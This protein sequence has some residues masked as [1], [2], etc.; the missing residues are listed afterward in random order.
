M[1]KSVISGVLLVESEELH[2]LPAMQ[3]A[4][5]PAIRGSDLV[6]PKP[7]SQ[8]PRTLSSPLG[9]VQALHLPSLRLHGL[10]EVTF[11]DLLVTLL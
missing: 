9:S 1:P 6:P 10:G 7:R 4:I 2:T 8:I 5:D 11:G 3:C